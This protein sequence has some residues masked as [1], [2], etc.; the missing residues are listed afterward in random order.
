MISCC[1]GFL[2]PL[3]SVEVTV[4]I[5]S[6][7]QWPGKSINYIGRR[8]KVVVES[9]VLPQEVSLRYPFIVVFQ[10]EKSL[11]RSEREKFCQKIFHNTA[12]KLPLTRL[13]L[14]LSILLPK[15]EEHNP[16]ANITQASNSST[17]I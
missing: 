8:H 9:L 17:N 12:T 11:D 13:Y 5:P 4:V 1:H 6:L 16:P 3:Q 2:E 10:T 7:D 14:K 15:I